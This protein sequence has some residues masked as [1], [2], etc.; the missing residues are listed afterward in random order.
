MS[1]D[2]E[3]EWSELRHWI[4]KTLEHIEARDASHTEEIRD[5]RIELAVLKTKVVFYGAG[6]AAIISALW[7]VVHWAITK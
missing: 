5:I 6:I 7:S 1:E 2:T 3:K 4:L